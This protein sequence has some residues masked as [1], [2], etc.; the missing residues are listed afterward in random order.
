M[1]KIALHPAEPHDDA[2]DDARIPGPI[3]IRDYVGRGTFRSTGV[4]VA[5]DVCVPLASSAA[6]PRITLLRRVVDGL[7]LTNRKRPAAAFH[8]PVVVPRPN[9]GEFALTPT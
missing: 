8:F 1:V 2:P 5:N 6:E 4:V 7:I 3:H 9:L